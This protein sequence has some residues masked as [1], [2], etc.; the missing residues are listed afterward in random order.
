MFRC[1]ICLVLLIMKIRETLLNE[2]KYSICFR[3]GDHIE[4]EKQRNHKIITEDYFLE[5]MDIYRYIV[6]V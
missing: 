5:A 1:Y 4:H 6:Y 3:R 2:Y